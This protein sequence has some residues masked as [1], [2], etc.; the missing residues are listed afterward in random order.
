MSFVS[1]GDM[2]AASHAR[3]GATSYHAGLAAEDSVE[4]DYLRQGMTVA[5]RRWR[6]TAG[7][8]DLIL[9]DGAAVIFVEV[10]KSRSFARAAVRI[11]RGQMDRICQAAGEFLAGEPAGQ[12]TDVR[13][14]LAL[15]DGSGRVHVTENAFMEA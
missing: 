6:G 4:R 10:K 14:D 7:E 8:I 1:R 3:T 5:A 15:V 13:F 11:G 9:R 12:L 2:V